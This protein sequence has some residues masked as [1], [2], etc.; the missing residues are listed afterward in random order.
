MGGLC[1]PELLQADATA[2][3]TA[4]RQSHKS[5]I[6]VYLSG[7][8]AHQDT[9]DLKPLAPDG[10]RGEFKPIATRLPGVQ[11]SELLPR[12]AAALDKIAVIRSLVGLRDEHSSFQ[13]LT[14]FTMNQS[15]REGKPSFGSVIAKMQGAVD[16]VI[17]PFIDLFPV[18]QHRPYNSPGPGFLGFAYKQARMDGDDLAL[19][20]APENVPPARF[21]HRRALLDQFDGFRRQ[22]ETIADNGMSDVYRRAFDVL[23]SDKV[24]QALDVTREDPKLRDRYGIG[25]SQHLG[26]GAPMW[27]D[28]LLIA[29]R[30]AEAGAR[31]ITVAY[32]FWDTHG[33]NFS[34]LRE[35]LP[36]FD[37]GISALI[38]DIYA[39][40]LDNDI[41]VVVWGEFGRT[42]K[43][44]KDAGR[45]HWARVNSALLSGG[46]MKVGQVIGSTDKVG[47]MAA[48]HPI[49]YLDVLATIYHNLGIDPHAFIS[50]KADRP[51]QILPPTATPIAELI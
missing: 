8:L 42:P 4:P 35:R 23:T 26:D 50:D 13:N 47:G 49:P 32:G 38:E 41:T 25:S 17:P 34:W 39:R 48:S 45:D 9:F 33:Q 24:A 44:N 30:L 29:R 21:D 16:P 3:T 37:R 22:V 5:V 43:I 6:M 31:C 36:L 20:R 12:T 27:N 15:Q 1:L 11:I 51:V 18:M 2:A 46:G 40:G 14:G 7:G 28:Q 19:L 10:V